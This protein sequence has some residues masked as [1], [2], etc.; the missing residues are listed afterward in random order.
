MRFDIDIYSDNLMLPVE[1]L[2]AKKVAPQVIQRIVRLRDIYNFM[3]RNPLKKDREYIDYIQANYTDGSGKPLSRRRA[4]ED[5]EIL[6]AVVG[7]LQQCTK[8]WHRW[9]FNNM[10]MEAYAIAL[11][12]EDAAAIAR[13][14]GEYGRY[15]KLDK[16]DEHDRGYGQI[17]H[18]VFNF[19][20]E[21]MGFKPIPN[22]RRVIDELIARYS[23][24]TYQ[25][26][27]EDADVVELADAVAGKEKQVTKQ[28]ESLPSLSSITSADSRENQYADATAIS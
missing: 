1:E 18:I 17:P 22:V 5:V 13:L 12:K 15:N 26:I 24:S 28:T 2:K 11:R 6:H 10:I 8:E 4:Y 9:R 25:D 21:P 14:A 27:A 19:N 16:E 7:S 3:L 23:H 20:V